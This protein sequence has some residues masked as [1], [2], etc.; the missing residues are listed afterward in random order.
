[1]PWKEVSVI[2]LRK[3]FI[4]LAMKGNISQLCKNFGIS[5]QAGYKWIRRYKNCG[6]AGLEDRSRRPQSS[7]GQVSQKIEDA[8]I[9]IRRRHLAWGGR[10]IRRRLENLGFKNVPAASTI[11]NILQRNGLMDQM[12]SRKHS[13][14]DSFQREQP[15]ELWQMDFKGHVPCPEGRCHPMT[16]LD[17]CSRYAL[18]IQACLDERTE[19]VQSCL[20]QTFRRYGLPNQ[21][22]MDNGSPWGNDGMNPYTRLTVWLMRLGIVVSHSRPAHPQTLGK[23]ERFHRTF[24]AELL[25]DSIPWPNNEAQRRFEEW[26]FIYNHQRPHDA[27]R[28]EVPASFYQ[29]SRRPFPEYLP[30]IEYGP[31]DIVRKIQQNGILHFRGKEFRVPK[32][33]VGEPIALRARAQSDGVFD[34]FYVR[35]FI[36]VIVLNEHD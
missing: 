8:V 29:I 32:A 34:V 18:A 35:Q 7:P 15:N 17:D 28:M 19:T 4:E 22:I 2:S 25:G 33:L 1:M 26:R 36:T 16:V 9:D 13:A 24:K 30:P 31:C 5:R 11:T 20:Q 27:L 21:M 14:F 10:K 12:Q 3:E 23:D 6:E